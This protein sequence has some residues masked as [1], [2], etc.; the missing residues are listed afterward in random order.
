MSVIQRVTTNYAKKWVRVWE[1]EI[2]RVCVCTVFM[3]WLKDKAYWITVC[4][5]FYFFRPKFFR[6][7]CFRP[8]IIF[9]ETVRFKSAIKHWL[10]QWKA[11]NEALKQL[12]GDIIVHIRNRYNKLLQLVNLNVFWKKNKTVQI[13]SIMNNQNFTNLSMI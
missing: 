5:R 12:A 11:E 1:R 8:K 6:P 3:P 13:S 2:E 9:F 7:K 4:F 10:Y